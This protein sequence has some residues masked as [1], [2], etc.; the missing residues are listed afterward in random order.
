ML[1]MSILILKPLLQRPKGLSPGVMQLWKLKRL[2]YRDWQMP[3]GSCSVSLSLLLWF[4]VFSLFSFPGDLL[5]SNKVSNTFKRK[6]ITLYPAFL[7]ALSWEIFQAFCVLSFYFYVLF[8]PHL[9]KHGNH[10]FLTY[11]VIFTSLNPITKNLERCAIFKVPTLSLKL[12]IKIN[13][14][15]VWTSIIFISITSLHIA[16]LS[17]HFTSFTK[18]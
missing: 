6:F 1:Y 12:K 17:H 3:P 8:F 10:K 13:G 18:L 9:L 11:Y 16:Y 2:G 5:L 14:N 4:F 15:F 7:T